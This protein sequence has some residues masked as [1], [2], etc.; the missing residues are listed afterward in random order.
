M[1]IDIKLA[2]DSADRAR[3]FFFFLEKKN[4]P[5]VEGRLLFLGEYISFLCLGSCT[6]PNSC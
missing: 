3:R 4:I 6:L 1:F 5:L 2:T